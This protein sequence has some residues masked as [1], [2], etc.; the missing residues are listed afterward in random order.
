VGVSGIRE[1]ILKAQP[2]FLN[3]ISELK[4]NQ[5]ILRSSKKE[6]FS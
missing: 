2:I 5:V 1:H 6:A 3:C 4:K